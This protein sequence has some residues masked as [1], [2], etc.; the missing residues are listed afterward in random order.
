MADIFTKKQRS[1]IMSAIRSK[2]TSVETIIFRL[3]RNQGIHFQKHYKKAAGCPDIALPSR[4][5]AVFI[6]GDFWHGYR[7]QTL[8]KRLPNKF[9]VKKIVRNIERD[10]DNRKKLRKSGWKVLRI[11]EHEIT[12]DA[13][14]TASKIAKFLT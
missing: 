1:K 9:W 13:K 2:N 7:F 4:K 6:D 10:K 8:R 11:W 3:L 12:N 14:S 5:K